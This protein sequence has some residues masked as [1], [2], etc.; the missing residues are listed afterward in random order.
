MVD[1]ATSE[2]VMRPE[3]MLGLFVALTCLGRADVISIT[4]EN[5]ETI[6]GGAEPAFLKFYSPKC[7]HCLA[8]AEDFQ[9]AS[10]ALP[11]VTF[12]AVDCLANPD[13]CAVY[14]VASWPTLYLF[15]V[16]S[17]EPIPFPDTGS[18]SF[19]GFCDF[20]EKQTGIKARRAPK[21]FALVNPLTLNDTIAST[22]CFFLTYYQFWDGYAKSW[23]PEAKHVAIAFL[24]EPNVSVGLLNCPVYIDFCETHKGWSA[25]PP[26][27][28]LY[29]NG[30]EIA[31]EGEWNA[32]AAVDYL[33]SQCGTQRQMSGLLSDE[34]GL[35]SGAGEVVSEFLTKPYQADKAI[36]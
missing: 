32:E 29:L 21:I 1:F 17:K 31:Y 36:E 16:G 11:A 28:R 7:K 3:T 23:L 14:Q 6:I 19:D 2:K 20:V 5:N 4:A 34:A 9:L 13:L 25:A 12:G 10:G 24:G 8:M 26:K 35:V 30:E 27:L 22:K 18:R 33:N 15:P